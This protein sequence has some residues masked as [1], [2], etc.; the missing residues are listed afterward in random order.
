MQTNG[1]PR[2]KLSNG[3]EST[4]KAYAIANSIANDPQRRRTLVMM[5]RE[6]GLRTL[7][8][9]L[10]LFKLDGGT[11]KGGNGAI[12]IHSLGKKDQKKNWPPETS[13]ANLDHFNTDLKQ[14]VLVMHEGMNEGVS[15]KNVE[16]VILADQTP[17]LVIPKI[18]D[19][20]QRIG[21]ALRMCGHKEIEKQKKGRK[22][23]LDIDLFVVT[24]DRPGLAP[25][26]DQEKLEILKEL[27]REGKTVA[28]S[29]KLYHMS[30]DGILY[31]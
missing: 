28:M 8:R 22:A 13:V 27:Y 19:M 5:H 15:V 29:R 11:G 17:S 31:T 20:N 14:R 6:T 24:H 26:I 25:T 3:M 30:F 1:F 9:F 18:G 16:R 21:R 10:E 23:R 4:T 7:Q 12:V 2:L